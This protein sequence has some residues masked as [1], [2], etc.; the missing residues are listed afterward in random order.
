MADALFVVLK[1]VALSLGEGA[2]TKIAS[3]VVEAAPILT[4]FEHSVKQIEGELSVM[5][6]FIGQVR[7]QK[8][9]DRAFDA[10]LDQVRD[11]AHEL[12]DIIDEYAYLT[13][14]AANTGSFF[15]RKFHQV[16]NF[17]AWQKLPTRISQVEAR[18]RRLAEMRNQYGISV[19][20]I[21]RSDKLQIPN[22]LSVSDSAYLT[23][24]SEI[25]GHADEI[26]I[27]TQWLLEEKQDRTLIAIIGMGGLGKTTVVS[28]VYKN[29]KIRRSFDCHAWVTVSQT[30]Q[31]EEL[32]R[33]IISQLIEQRAS[34]AS[35]LMTMSRMRLVEKIQ[36]YLR[37]NKYLIVL[38]D[39]WDKDAWLYLNH[40]FVGNNCGSKV[41]ITTRRK[42]VSYLAAHNRIIELKTLNYA[43]SW[44][45]FCKKAFCASKDNICPM[46]LRSLAGKIVYKCQGLPLAI[47]IIGSI[48][49]Y[50][51][52]DAQEW[53]FFYNQLSWQL[54]NNP[55][56]SWISSVLNLSLDDLPCHLRSCF[57]Y[58]SLFPEDHKIKRKLIAKLWI[59]EGLVEERGDAATMEEVAEHYLVELTHRSLLQVIER[60]ASGRART[61]LMHDLVREVTSVTAQKEKFAAIHGTAG[62]AHVSQK[63]RRL[64]VQKVVDSQNYLASSHLRSFILFDTVV[65][66]S[67]IYDV[68]S[69]FRLLRVLCLRFTNIEQVPDVV[70]ELYN[71]RYLDI[72]Y[73]KV[74]WISPS[75]RKLVNLQVLD[76]R[77]SY[78]KELPLEITMLTNLR[79]LHVCV[80][81]DI[82]ERSLNCFS[83]T[84]F[85]GNICGLKNLQALH[86]VST[87]KDLVLQLG[88]LTMMRSLSVMK[89]RQSYIAEL[90]NSLTKMPNLSRLLL[91]ASD[92]DEILNLKMLRPLPD[93]KLLWLAGK[94]DGGTVPSLFSK[95]EKLTLLKM[96]WTGLKKDPIRSFSHM[97]TLVNLG[98]RGAYGGEHLSFCAGWFPKLKYLQL[99]DMEHLSCILMEDGTMIGLHHLELIGLRNI[100][101][102][103]KGIKYIRTLHQMFLTDMPM[104]FVESL[105]GSAS[106]IVQH[107]TNVHIFDSSDSEAVNNF[108]FWPHLSKKYGSGAAKYDPT[109]E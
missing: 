24:N 87:N 44:E 21:D 98:L 55:E 90:W 40:A 39:I 106:H 53:S 48:L 23:D 7:A 5:L 85:R 72:S 25:V 14:Q 88:N 95:F 16:R 64:C 82:Q 62:V 66:S 58:C 86:T 46:N 96:D 3:E 91:F 56:L 31:V 99:A 34:M 84:K 47:V 76:L 73:T 59:A 28:S 29:Q 108:I 51:E 74:K 70:T 2:L 83:D 43:E 54:A 79:H 17:A 37:D 30:Y 94:L 33:E 80:V 4:D 104:E 8:A 12:E 60:N 92:M 15:K 67:W 89:V 20:E 71:L 100:R 75:F 97:S 69:H 26:G 102:V 32:L 49:S 11:V 78:V 18:I 52:L 77:F 68:S 13:V 35:G 45:L 63:A 65:P 103:P 57:L 10:W 93:L 107:V 1:K 42:D 36:S 41:L 9:A 19:G 101:A 27:L 50:R 109:A 38:D 22:Q 105:R 81:H 6:A 61:F